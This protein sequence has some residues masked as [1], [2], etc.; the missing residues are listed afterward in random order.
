MFSPACLLAAAGVA[1]LAAPAMAQYPAAAD[2]L[3][4]GGQQPRRRAVQHRVRRELVDAV[5]RH[6]ARQRIARHPGN[7][8]RRPGQP[9][10]RE[11]VDLRVAPRAAPGQEAQVPLQLHPAEVRRRTRPSPARSS[12]TASGSR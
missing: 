2:G 1:V 7:G 4:R 10:R 11:A 8:H 6:R 3:L 5:A 9:R 12:S